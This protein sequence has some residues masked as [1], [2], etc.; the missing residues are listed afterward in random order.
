MRRRIVAAAV[1]VLTAVVPVIAAPGASGQSVSG[2]STGAST[3][4]SKK[5][6]KKK[7]ADDDIDLLRSDAETVRAEIDKTE[8]ARTEALA[9]L[10]AVTVEV[11][12]AREAERVATEAVQEAQDLVDEIDAKVA[13]AMRAAYTSNT[14][15]YPI[16]LAYL[17]DSNQASMRRRYMEHWAEKLDVL[18]D[19][20]ERARSEL[21]V[22]RER[23]ADATKAVEQRQSEAQVQLTAIEELE[24]NQIQ[25]VSAIEQRLDSALAEAAAI[26]ELDKAMAQQ[27]VAREQE[28]HAA[29]VASAGADRGAP[30]GTAAVAGNTPTKGAPVATGGPGST[31]PPASAAPAPGPVASTAP[32]A[33]AATPTTLPSGTSSVDVVYVRGIPVARSIAA[34]FEAMLSAASSAGLVISGS[35][36]R[37]ISVQIGLRAKNCGPSDFEIWFKPSS[38]CSP[39]TAIP[40]RSMHEKGLAVDLTCDGVLIPSRT[41]KCFVWLAA[42]AAT[43]GLKN[44][45]SEPWHWSTNGN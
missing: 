10:G 8:A 2:T 35:G 37:D 1:A 13:M 38:Q 19:E 36:Y 4:A 11:E 41:N 30:A 23:A 39:P 29:A 22:E 3:G 7:T 45:P 32:P 40:G 6:T 25:L 9:T 34:N 17:V 20:Q 33:T 18:L 27:I 5:S 43:Y 42:N 16:E 14:V 15:D 26:E 28:L 12:R 44:L 24:S 31:A 21:A